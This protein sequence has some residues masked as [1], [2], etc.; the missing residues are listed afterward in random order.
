MQSELTDRVEREFLPFVIKPGRYVGNEFNSIHKDHGGLVRVALAFPDLYDIGMSHVGIHILYHRINSLDYAVAERVFAPSND[1]EARLRSTEIPLFS[2]ESRVS[3]KEFDLLGFTIAYELCSSNVLNMLDLSGIPLRAKDRTEDDPVVIFGGPCVFNPEPLADFADA[4]F[5]GDGE[6]AVIEIVDVIRD[7]KKA[8]R[9]TLISRLSKIDGMYIPSYYKP[10]FVKGKFT[11]IKKSND[12]APDVITSRKLDKLK[13]EHYPTKPIVPFVEIAHDRL[14]VEIMRG[15]GHGCRFC[16]AGII[17]RPK[18]ERKAQDIIKQVTESLAATGFSDLTLLSLSSSDYS[19]IES[20]VST[21]STR[22]QEQHVTLS[23]PSLRANGFTEDLAKKL[24][25]TR[26]TG[27]TLAPEAG[28]D[29]LREVINKSIPEEE[30]LATIKV[31]FENGW[32]VLKLYFMVGLPTETNEDLDGICA[33]LKKIAR[34]TQVRPGKRTINVTTSPFCPKP[35]TPWQW[36]S[37]VGHDDIVEKQK[38][39][40]RHSPRTV[41]VKFRNADV[42]LLESALGRGDR[43]VGDVIEHAFKNGARLDAWSEHLKYDVW[44]AAFEA[45]GLDIADFH[46][47]IPFDAPLPWDHISKGLK[48]DYFQREA[49]RSKGLLDQDKLSAKETSE[50]APEKAEKKAAPMEYGRQSKRVKTATSMQ[51]P[52]SKVRVKWGKTSDVRFLSHLD[53]TRVFERA[54]RREKIPVSYSQGYHPHQRLAFGPP[55]TLGYWSEAEYL[56]IQ[57][58]APYSTGMFDRLNEALPEGFSISQTKP[59]F[60]KTKSLSAMINLACYEVLLPLEL[61]AAEEKRDAI[62]AMESFL[63]NRKT[64][65]DIIEVDI[66]PGIIELDLTESDGGTILNLMTG[67]GTICFARPSEVIQHGFELTAEQVLALTLHR[68]DLLIQREEK[69]LTPFE[70]L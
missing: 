7:R 29:R 6:E 62:L 3:L 65:T 2:L 67:L 16:Q 28:T 22:L 47:E 64:K 39:V 44:I 59:I 50:P 57:L 5:I 40:S 13:N 1:A 53:N 48:K 17:Y 49:M 31:A 58:D 12:A 4:V 15:C 24:G 68:K 21:L 11:G 8:K 55:L 26:R 45:C 60:G 69:R 34:F 33:L 14:P 43:R 30:F 63:V 52:N 51:V 32:N 41:N 23:L 42:T 19:E 54:L 38:Y 25:T 36:E 37:Q 46:K 10:G 66:R 56:D 9:K 61:S 70:V 18:R 20:L 27:L 35:H